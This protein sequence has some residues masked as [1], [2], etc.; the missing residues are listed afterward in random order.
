M[1][2]ND[3]E[4]SQPYFCYE[5]ERLYV[6]LVAIIHCEKGWR[7]TIANEELV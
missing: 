6:L 3:E 4:V 2:L 1:T 5:L 7:G